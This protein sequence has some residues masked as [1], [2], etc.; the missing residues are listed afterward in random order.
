MRRRNSY[1]FARARARWRTGPSV[2]ATTDRIREDR[3]P[4]GS[5]RDTGYRRGKRTC[6]KNVR[7]ADCDLD[8]SGVRARG[9]A[10]RGAAR[11]GETR[12]TYT[13]PSSVPKGSIPSAGLEPIS[14][15]IR[16]TFSSAPRTSAGAARRVI[17]F[18]ARRNARVQFNCPLVRVKGR[19]HET[20]RNIEFMWRRK[21]FFLCLEKTAKIVGATR[22]NALGNGVRLGKSRK[23]RGRNFRRAR[24]R[25]SRTGVA[26]EARTSV[27]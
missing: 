23:R 22:T 19:L 15:S 10:R 24:A 27:R 2:G 4:I 14:F 25:T 1:R 11:R 13:R 20:T 6:K 9:E 18:R 16:T 17:I 3:R 5:T 21:C 26:H 12:R 8:R 7:R